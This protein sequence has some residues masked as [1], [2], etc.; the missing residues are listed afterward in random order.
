MFRHLGFAHTGR[1]G[2]Q[3]VAD[4]LFRFPQTGSGQFD[5]AGQSLDS[6]VLTEHHP[7]QRGFEVFQHLGIVLGDVL[8][9]NAGDLGD[10]GLNLFHTDGLA[11]LAFRDQM[12]CRAGLINHVDG[13]V[14]Q[15]AVVDIARGQFH[16][17][18]DRIGG[19]F[20]V[21]MFLEIGFQTAQDFHAVFDRR[22]IHVDLLEPAAERAVLFEMLTEFLVGGRS[23]GAQLAALQGRFQQVRGIHRPARGRTSTD[24]GVNFVNEQHRVGVV[25]QFSHHRL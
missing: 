1:T 17:R 15:L 6:F 4:G 13:F 19:V 22:L 5:G 2:E 9:R 18:L 23:H 16:R 12:L 8:G 24:H 7:F 10:N 25:F 3:I 20:D 11:T 14:G 21:V